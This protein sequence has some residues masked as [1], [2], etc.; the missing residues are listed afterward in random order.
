M[1]V[2]GSGAVADSMVVCRTEDGG[3]SWLQLR[4]GLPQEAAFDLVY[5]HALDRRGDE[6]AF[7]STTGN[8]FW[9]GDGGDS[10]RCLGNHF[11]PI[12]SVR[13]A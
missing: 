9:S 5:R 7:G 6:L 1:K 13:F 3:R 8:L 12:Y 11:A 4:D 10:W 2:S